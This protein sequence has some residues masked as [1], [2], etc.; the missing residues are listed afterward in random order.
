MRTRA[1]IRAGTCMYTYTYRARPRAHR[2]IYRNKSARRSSDESGSGSAGFLCTSVAPSRTFRTNDVEARS[3]IC[4]FELPSG[5]RETLYL[6][7]RERLGRLWG[8]TGK[9]RGNSPQI[10]TANFREIEHSARLNAPF[11][12]RL[13]RRAQC[14][15]FGSEILSRDFHRTHAPRAVRRSDLVSSKCVG[16]RADV[17]LCCIQP[18]PLFNRIPP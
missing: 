11:D 9:R 18:T 8:L 1:H 10:I 3:D 13:L 6:R 7:A 14:D 5:L 16:R 15:D 2:C 17:W 4:V 12:R